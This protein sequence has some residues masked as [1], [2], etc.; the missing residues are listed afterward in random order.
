MRLSYKLGALTAA[1]AFFPL[2]IVSLLV[3]SKVSNHARQQAL[4]QLRSDSRAAASLYEE[5]VVELRGVAQ[6]LAVEI[7]SRALVSTDSVD[8]NS[9]GALARLQDILPRTQSDASLDLVIVTDP[10]GRVIA[11]HNDKPTPGETLLGSDDKNPVAERVIAGGNLPVASCVIERG[12]RYTRLGLDRTAAVR[13]ADGSVTDEALMI[14]AGAPIFSG[15]RIV[16]VVL[17]GQMLNTY[18][19]PRAVANSLQTPLVAEV[20]QTLARGEEEDAGAVIALGKFV[21]ASSIPPGAESAPVLAGALHDITK[22]EEVFQQGDHSYNVTWQPIKSL[23]GSVTGA[24]GVARPSK[25]LEGASGSVRVTILFVG[26]IALVLAA[27]AGFAFGLVLGNRVDDLTEATAR[28][29]VGE[30]SAPVRDRTPLLAKWIPAEYLR[31]EVNR[32][33]AQLDDMRESFRQAI[34]RMKKR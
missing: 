6:M 2:L 7:A 17:I 30:L 28:W 22:A 15:G 4:D 18:Y 13:L 20:R 8:R 9:G 11:R 14:E 26:L 3:H 21:V 19:K 10:L 34:E 29:S 27:G 24:I 1:A 16:G 23:D 32:L 5:R 12:E 31:D 33:A 25:E